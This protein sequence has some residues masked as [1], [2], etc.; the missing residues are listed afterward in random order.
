MKILIGLISATLMVSAATLPQKVAPLVAESRYRQS[1]DS[2]A[3]VELDRD[4]EDIAFVFTYQ[5]YAWEAT[6]TAS[7]LTCGGVQYSF[8]F[9]DEEYIK[10]DDLL[11]R[12]EKEKKFAKPQSLTK[13][14]QNL[15]KAC[16]LEAEQ[17]DTSAEFTKKHTACDAGQWTT[18]AVIDGKLVRLYSCGDNTCTM[19]DE[20]ANKIIELLNHEGYSVKWD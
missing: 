4:A 18:Y 20:H 5:N 10:E 9:S 19:Q 8:D 17:V 6:Y 2:A 16:L 11:S 14:D 13:A 15:L 12:L 3:N 1:L 7:F